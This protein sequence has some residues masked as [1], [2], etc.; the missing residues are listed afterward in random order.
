MGSHMH[1]QKDHQIKTILSSSID[2]SK[3]NCKMIKS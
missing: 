3:N 2:G 1:F